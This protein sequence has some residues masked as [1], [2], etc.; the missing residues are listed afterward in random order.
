MVN[1][2]YLRAGYL[3][4]TPCMAAAFKFGIKKYLDNFFGLL[5]RNITCRNAQ[6]IGIGMAAGRYGYFFVITNSR[7]YALVF[8]GSYSY[9]I[10]A[11]A[12][13]DAI[14]K[15]TTLH[16]RSYGVRKV[17]IVARIF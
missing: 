6:H 13:Q 1:S 2:I 4:N 7:A 16:R 17:G 12:K 5:Q 11:S 9:P 3:I 8:V 14:I 10:G 15:L